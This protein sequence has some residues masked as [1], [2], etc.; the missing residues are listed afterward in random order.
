[1]LKKKEKK[2]LASILML[3]IGWP[4][5]LDQFFE[6]K[7]EKGIFTTIGWTVTALLFLYGLGLKGYYTGVVLIIAVLFTLAGSFQACKKLIKVTRAFIDA[8][9]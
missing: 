9:D 6:G 1:M 8:E 7:N 5:G 2:A 3:L 4:V